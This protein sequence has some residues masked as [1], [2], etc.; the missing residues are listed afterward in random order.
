MGGD[1]K[2]AGFKEKDGDVAF[3]IFEDCTC[4]E[5]NNMEAIRQGRNTKE[6]RIIAG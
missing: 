5:S 1:N 2:I 3:L 4:Q 6:D